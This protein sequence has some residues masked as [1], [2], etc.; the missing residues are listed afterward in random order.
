VLVERG[1][2]E[3][4]RKNGGRGEGKFSSSWKALEKGRFFEEVLW[5]TY[6]PGVV[7]LNSIK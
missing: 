6:T 2:R 3:K 1:L 7:G 5:P 4:V